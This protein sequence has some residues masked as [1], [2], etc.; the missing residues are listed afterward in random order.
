MSTSSDGLTGEVATSLHRGTNWWGAFVIGLAGTILVTGIV[1]FA[2]QS[3]Y[4]V[5]GWNAPE[6]VVG[7]GESHILYILGIVVLAAYLPLYFWRKLTDRRRI[8]IPAEAT[9]AVSAEAAS[10]PSVAQFEP[11][12]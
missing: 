9:A 10:P 3:I 7:P 1:P 5:G 6:I 12:V 11:E 8:L 4:F 2:A